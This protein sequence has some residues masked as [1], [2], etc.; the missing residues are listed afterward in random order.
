MK[1][2][3]VSIL[4]SLALACTM[5]VSVF[6]EEEILAEETNEIFGADSYSEE[7]GSGEL[8]LDV[9]EEAEYG[10]GSD[11]SSGSAS[12]SVDSIEVLDENPDLETEEDAY[13]YGYTSDQWVNPIYEEVESTSVDTSPYM[14]SLYSTQSSDDIYSYSD[15]DVNKI[16]ADL[17][18]AM[19]DRETNFTCTFHS[20]SQINTDNF[21][22]EV[23]TLAFAETDDSRQGDS[24]RYST[25]RMSCSFYYGGSLESGYDYTCKISVESYTTK[26]QED[27][28]NSQIANLAAQFSK[29]SSAYNKAAAVYDYVCSNVKYVDDNRLNDNSDTLKYTAYEALMNGEAVCQGYAVLIYRLMRECGIPC[30]IVTGIGNG[31]PHA[32]N[33]IKI[34]SSY[35]YADATWD[36]TLVRNYESI[37]VRECPYFL[38]G[39]RDFDEFLSNGL[40]LSN[41]SRITGA[42]TGHE[43][44][45]AVIGGSSLSAYAVSLEKYDPSASETESETETNTESETETE[46]T[47]TE[48]ETETETTVTESETTPA[49]TESETLPSETT[50]TES[51]SET[52]SSESEAESET[53]TVTESETTAT[54]S[55]TLPTETTPTEAQSETTKQTERTEQSETTKQSETVKQSETQPAQHVH[56]W[57]KWTTTAAAT[58][59]HAEQQQR[60]CTAGHI[61]T[62]SVGSKLTPTIQVNASRI[63]LKTKQSTSKLQVSGLA[64]GDSVQS[65]Q[66]SNT[67]IFTVA[68][69]G[70]ITAKSKAGTAKLTIE[71]ASGLKK[72]V[73]V[74]VQKKA[75]ATTKITGVPK[76]LTLQIKSSQILKPVLAPITSVEKITYKSSNKKVASVNSKGKISAKKKGKAVITVKAGKKTVKCTVTVK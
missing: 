4:L 19:T 24:L 27:M 71:L 1:K 42:G 67:K 36:S 8:I 34:G 28:L 9:S 37:N 75:V 6:S 61:E 2:K 63:T 44:D 48:T 43:L 64:A 41:G 35:Y 20:S 32:W 11:Q 54:E 3:A 17:R 15:Y 45:T 52:K 53:E 60:V 69:N 72:T 25:G 16:G 55:E 31:G 38:R 21:L 70:K 33:I 47:A 74:K 13:T 14:L 12:I 51:E 62:R 40:T 39:S 73:T 76:K 50:P 57:R 59:A 7:A 30:R 56:S 65:Y 18:T 23:Q 49:E 26:G 66:S 22:S 10:A 5:P 46:T 58:V 29:E 68:R